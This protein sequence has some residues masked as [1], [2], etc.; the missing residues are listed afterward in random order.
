MKDS[1]NGFTI[2]AF[3]RAKCRDEVIDT[4]NYKAYEIYTTSE[5]GEPGWNIELVWSTP[6][7]IESY[8][9]F[10]AVITVNDCRPDHIW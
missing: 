7:R 10:D 5:K 3:N 6:E 4:R 1:D 8:P 2:K 9:L